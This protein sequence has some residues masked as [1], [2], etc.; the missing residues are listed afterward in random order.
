MTEQDKR[1]AFSFD[2]RTASCT[3][4]PCHVLF[5]EN[6]TWSSA[7]IKQFDPLK[8]TNKKSLSPYQHRVAT[9]QEC[10]D[11]KLDKKQEDCRKVPLQD[12]PVA[13]L[14]KDKYMHLDNRDETI[15]YLHGDSQGKCSRDSCQTKVKS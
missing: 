2:E 11:K 8:E 9:F 13:M 7:G 12:D 1:A 10:D 14:L 4:T 3:D 6:P 15:K 5:Y